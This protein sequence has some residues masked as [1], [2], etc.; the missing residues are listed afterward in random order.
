MH[1]LFINTDDQ[2]FD[3]LILI[4]PNQRPSTEVDPDV[5]QKENRNSEPICTVAVFPTV[6]PQ[7]VLHHKTI[8]NLI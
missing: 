5:W 2:Y 7:N 6:F 1:Y 4:D 8:L 3:T